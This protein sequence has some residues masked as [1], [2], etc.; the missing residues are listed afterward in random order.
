MS[1][2]PAAFVLFLCA[3]GAPKPRPAPAPVQGA[4]PPLVIVALEAQIVFDAEGSPRLPY[5]M[6]LARITARIVN[7]G[8]KTLSQKYLQDRLPRIKV[9]DFEE[10]NPAFYASNGGYWNPALG[11]GL[12]PGGVAQVWVQ[13][14]FLSAGEKKLTATIGKNTFTARTEVLAGPDCLDS[15]GGKDY[16]APGWAVGTRDCGPTVSCVTLVRHQDSCEGDTLT[17]FFCR[18]AG[19]DAHAYSETR[20]CPKGCRGGACR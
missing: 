13:G 4:A 10:E 17:E 1:R 6:E 14:S 20:A 15:D 19:K 11:K 16:D 18:G 2:F 9:Q 3:C 12:E 5:S 7:A 8:S